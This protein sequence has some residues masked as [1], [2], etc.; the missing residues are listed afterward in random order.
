MKKRAIEDYSYR[1]VEIA[2][3]I[4]KTGCTVRMASNIF[5]VSK[6]TVH[7]DVTE[8]LKEIN[9]VLYSSIRKV[10]EKNKSERHIRGGIATKNKYNSIKNN[11]ERK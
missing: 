1:C 10:M 2:K 4:L 8:K 7:K 11:N 6:S 3:Y 9:P 5:G